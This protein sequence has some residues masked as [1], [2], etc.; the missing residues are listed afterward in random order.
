MG[1]TAEEAKAL[2]SS[3]L[4]YSKADECEVACEISESSHTRFAASEVTTSGSTRDLTIA[5][6]S[7]SK[8][9]SGTARLNE[10]EPEALK[11]AVARSEELMAVA[12][13]DP[14]F[15]EALG[16]QTYQSI[17]A[18][19]EETE[20]A[21]AVQRREG[22]SAALEAA[23][24]RKLDSSGFLET[25]TTWTCIANS[26]GLFGFHRATDASYSTTMRTADGTGSGWAG[27]NSPRFGEIKAG[28]LA[29]R[30]ARKAESSAKPRELAPGK[31]TVILEPQAVADLLGN[32]GFALSGRAADEGRGYF[33][34]PGGGNRIGEKLFHDS[35]TLVSDPFDPRVPGRPW[36]GG[37]VGG[38]GGGGGFGGGQ[39]GFTGLPA[40]RVVWIENG[41]VKNLSVDRYWAAKTQKEPVPYSGSLVMSGGSGSPEDLIAGVQRGLLVTRFWYIRAVNPQTMQVTGLT[42]DGVWLIE[43][44]VIA[45]PVNNFRFNESPANLLK[46]IEALSA[47][48]PAGS[49]VVPAIRAKEFNFSSR[50]DAV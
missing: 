16:P 37:G 4:S 49:V 43:G 29:G 35:V 11:K 26:R 23:R 47:A 9:R 50:S 45:G 5:I 10:S 15:V 28:E 40:R 41:V 3:I 34:K 39:G 27:R 14:E 8:G 12:P 20:K 48:V 2:A 32:L 30:A 36:A 17:P 13:A 42:R 44:G 22:V 21:G 7:R 19:H 46:N 18:Y 25:E 6:T 38:G 24:S 31:Y 33:A 1:W